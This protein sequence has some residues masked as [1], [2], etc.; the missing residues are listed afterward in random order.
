MIILD[1]NKVSKN[2]GYGS[3]F[4]NVTF[5]LN[6]GESISIVGHNGCGKSTLLRLIAKEERLD[7]GSISIKKDATV[8]YLDQIISDKS[9]NRVVKDILLE[10]F[11]EINN[12]MNRIKKYEK[13][14]EEDSEKYLE[15][16][17]KLLEEYSSLGGYDVEVRINT[18]CSGLG[19]S[20]FLLNQNYNSLSGGEKTLVQLAKV[21]LLKPD[22]LLLDEPTNHLDISRVEWL[23]KYIK[24]FK[25]ACV[26]VSHDRYFLD[27]MSSKI[28]DL[29]DIEAK[30]YNTNY[31]GYLVEREKEFQKQL[32]DYK[33]QQ[34]VIKRLQ[35]QIKY[36]SE[37]GMATNSSTLC[38]RAKAL[39]TSLNRILERKVEKPKEQ[40]E[41]VVD[42]NETKRGS[43]IV[44]KSENLSV[45][46][47]NG[48]LILD[49]VS[50]II[51]SREKVAFIGDNGSGKS[52]FLKVVLSMSDLDYLGNFFIGPS[53]NI[54]YLPQ[55]ITFDGEKVKV[56]DY[57][58]NETCLDEQKSRA[59]LAS[60]HFF[61]DDVNKFIKNLS[62]GERVRL[63]LAI[64]LQSKVN[65]LIF[66]EPTNHIDIS[67]K[68]VLER[69][70]EGFK[71]TFIFVSHD[72][73]F[74]N[75]FADKVVEFNNGNLTVYNGNYDYYKEIKNK[76]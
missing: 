36:F 51:K 37:R 28:L 38:N 69:A 59:I 66:D 45:M 47:P 24:S 71:G 46:K 52:T 20:D 23:E 13:L 44:L 21:L 41:L 54:G 10:T 7:N 18:V 1:V 8:A 50:L 19:I 68:E 76:N 17:C 74:I 60:F 22:L 57:F 15:S 43:E 12:L 25:G 70:V 33:N 26:I 34:I 5:S 35:E 64:L 56:L 72:R 61:K 73:Y 49:D 14:M 63:K 16:Y 4:E 53:V 48:D 55:V 40:R 65:C 6:E 31:S 42:F 39:Q 27:K 30:V 11:K 29:S 3:L 67:T 9:D 2:F 75:K 32:S 62:G 58:K